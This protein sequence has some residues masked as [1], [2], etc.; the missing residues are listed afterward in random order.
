M[1]SLY[2]S[3]IGSCRR[4]LCAVSNGYVADDVTLTTPN[5]SNFYILVAYRVFVVGDRSNFKFSILVDHRKFQP[6]DDKLSLKGVWSSHVTHFKF[7]VLRQSLNRLK[8]KTSIFVHW[9]AMYTG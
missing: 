7:L 9:M 5:H 4:L 6:E 2:I 1:H 3:Q 8:L